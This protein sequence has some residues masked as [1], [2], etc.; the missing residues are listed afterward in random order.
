MYGEDNSNW[1]GG[2]H[3]IYQ[4][5]RNSPQYSEWRSMVFG[6]D[7]Y[8]CRE[9]GIRGTYFEAHHIK[10]FNDIIKQYNII[11]LEEA[12]LCE[13]LWDLDNGITLCKKCH[14]RITFCGEI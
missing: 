11:T 14:K 6:R 3:P 7:L 4:K 10:R 8:T 12:L 13:E 5:I 2:I 1:K 9:C